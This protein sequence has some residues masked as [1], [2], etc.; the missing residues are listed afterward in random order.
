[1][2]RI[3]NRHSEIFCGSETSIFS[4]SQLYQDWDKYKGRLLKK[5]VFGLSNAGWHN[6]IGVMLDDEYDRTKKELKSLL[7]E[8]DSFPSFINE[9]YKPILAGEQKSIWAE[10]TPSNAFT[11]LPFLE[12]FGSED[13]VIHIV[14]H[15]LDTIASLV[16]R[17]MTAYNA[18]S[19]YLLNVNEALKTVDSKRSHLIKY[20]DL[21]SKSEESCLALCDF[22]G[23]SYE[24]GILEP[25]SD[26]GGLTQMS[27]WLSDETAKPSSISVGRYQSLPLGHRKTLASYVQGIATIDKVSITSLAERLGYSLNL[28]TEIDEALLALMK[29]ERQTDI[30]KR[31]FSNYHFKS[32]NY[33]IQ[34]VD[35]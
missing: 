14:R 12:S 22:I 25:K 26:E 1:M 34:I 13:Q 30:R 6:F 7:E 15:P 18:T 27:G 9:F 28:R 23:V 33:P 32:H 29:S 11:L 5:S 31:R 20:E 24:P 21:V 17:G 16:A 3:L 2:R 35:H 10:K 8:C 19:I 4:K